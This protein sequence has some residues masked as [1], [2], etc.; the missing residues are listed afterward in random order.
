MDTLSTLYRAIELNE[1]LR[2]T[3]Q[4]AMI[5]GAQNYRV[6]RRGKLELLITGL[7]G[8]GPVRVIRITGDASQ[9][10]EH[11]AYLTIEDI[12][13]EDPGP[14]NAVNTA[15]V[16]YRIEGRYPYDAVLVS[17]VAFTPRNA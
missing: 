2:E 10:T 17:A 5:R 6:E 12:T 9:S 3:G 16:H 13:I 1:L 14:N 8:K 4:C 7:R 15:N 11:D